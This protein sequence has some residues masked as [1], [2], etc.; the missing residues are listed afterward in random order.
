MCIF[1]YN[2]KMTVCVED[3]Q[4]K[5]TISLDI[6][7]LFDDLSESAL[8]NLNTVTCQ[9]LEKN[10]SISVEERTI[11]LDNCKKT[12]LLRDI[13]SSLDMIETE[14]ELRKYSFD[15]LKKLARKENIKI[16]KASSR[17]YLVQA[18]EDVRASRTADTD[19]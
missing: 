13:P 6:S 9:N 17:E 2:P 11:T 19:S 1:S 14:E 16:G 8:R 10:S 18:L 12:T 5:C 4:T 15:A 7:P 3:E